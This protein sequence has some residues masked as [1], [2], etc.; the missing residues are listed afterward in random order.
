MKDEGSK[1]DAHDLL[2]DPLLTIAEASKLVKLAE[3]TLRGL[4][5]NGQLRA[6]RVRDRRMIRL[7]ELRK[8]VQD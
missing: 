4:I 1:T 7:S 6:A 2:D 3:W 5:A 8:L